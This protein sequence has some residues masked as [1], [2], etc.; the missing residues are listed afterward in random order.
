MHS[1]FN[2]HLRTLDE[3]ANKARVGE[4]KKL[5][6]FEKLYELKSGSTP[7]YLDQNNFRITNLVKSYEIEIQIL[8]KKIAQLDAINQ[9]EVTKGALTTEERTLLTE[10]NKN[11]DDKQKN[12][13]LEPEYQ[14]LLKSKTLFWDGICETYFRNDLGAVSSGK[15]YLEK[16]IYKIAHSDLSIEQ[17]RNELTELEQ[18]LRGGKVCIPAF[19]N[20]LEML[21]HK[22]TIDDAPS[23]L[24]SAKITFAHQEAN[25]YLVEK[26][27]ND[28]N[29]P[30]KAVFLTNQL[31]KELNV[32]SRD[33][34]NIQYV[35]SFTKKDHTTYTDRVKENFPKKCMDI[36]VEDFLTYFDAYDISN[37]DNY[38][39]LCDRLG[40]VYESGKQYFEEKGSKKSNNQLRP[41]I[42]SSIYRRFLKS[43]ML[44]NTTIETKKPLLAVFYLPIQSQKAK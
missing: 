27:E 18:R 19:V 30:H 3:K 32:L 8:I 2:F 16:I 1:N 39:T 24:C 11:G 14:D 36:I 10:T 35:E 34:M 37:I 40:V 12:M 22:L 38:F 42:E 21:T 41:L 13:R 20:E 44:D 15:K 17:I 5:S 43:N 28:S 9:L 7:T 29:M 6:Y 33:D 25:T 26:K 23:L 31:P 4:D